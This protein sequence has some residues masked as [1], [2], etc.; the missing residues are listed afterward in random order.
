MEY[1]LEAGDQRG[2]AGRNFC[3]LR[4]VRIC[5]ISPIVPDRAMLVRQEGGGKGIAR[6]D[7]LGNRD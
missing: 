5:E 1:E 2:L 3:I 6:K 7:A 4:L